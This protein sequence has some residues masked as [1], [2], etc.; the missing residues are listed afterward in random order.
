MTIEEVLVKQYGP[1]LSLESWQRF[2]IDLRR[3]CA[4]V[5]DHQANGSAESMPLVCGSVVGS[6]F[7]PQR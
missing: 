1:L 7:V 6:I 3:A 2:S 5:S 4:S